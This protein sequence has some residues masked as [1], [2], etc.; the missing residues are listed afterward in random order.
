MTDRPAQPSPSLTSLARVS[1]ETLQYQQRADD[2]AWIDVIHRMDVVY[3]DLVR[4]Q[5]ELENKNDEL[6]NTKNFIQSVITSISDILIVCDI[7]GIILQVNNALT[8][9]IG[10]SSDEIL[11]KP[12]SDLFSDN[13]KTLISD[14]PEHIRS[15][16]IIDCEID[17]VNTSNKLVPMSINCSARYD[18]ENRLSGFVITGHPIGDLRK[19]FSEL[20]KTHEELKMTQQHLVQSEKMAS[21]GR[22]VA[23]VAHELN[24]PIS[25]LYANMHALKSYEE[26][27]I[28]YLDAIHNDISKD[29]REKL[30]AELKVDRIMADIEPL[31][32]GSLE[33]AERVSE[34][35]QNLSKFTTPQKQKKQSFNLISVIKRASSWVLNASSFTPEIIIDYPEDFALINNEGHVHQILINLIQNAVDAVKNIKKPQLYIS[36]QKKHKSIEIYIGDNGYG[37]DPKDTNKIFDPFYTT[38]AVGSG[39]GLGLYIS[40]GLAIEQCNGDLTARNHTSGGAEFI[41]SL[42]LEES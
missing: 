25:F 11:G 38:K 17:L 1:S 30:R 41:L 33:G 28:A 5:V 7:N 26:K 22:L 12:V 3:T 32:E 4:S 42:P 40:Y 39:T 27:F 35:V 9:E 36:I 29:A 10:L 19:A 18:H 37:I 8:N 2:Q 23:G 16:N 13:H 15:D 20:K 6:E 34:I 24:N 14:F 21:L 31:V